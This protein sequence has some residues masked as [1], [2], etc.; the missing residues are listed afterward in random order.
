[1][2]VSMWLTVRSEWGFDVSFETGSDKIQSRYRMWNW[3]KVHPSKTVNF[4]HFIYNSCL[5]F[6]CFAL[7]RSCLIEL[8][9]LRLSK[10]DRMSCSPELFGPILFRSCKIDNVN[11]TINCVYFSVKLLK[12]CGYW[13]DSSLDRESKVWRVKLQIIRDGIIA[14]SDPCG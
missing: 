10:A 5:V 2:H 11:N 3:S 12:G 14:V 4:K 6:T 8:R 13:L 7:R 9:L 1:M